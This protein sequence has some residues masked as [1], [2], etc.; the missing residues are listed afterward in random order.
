MTAT[1]DGRGGLARR[2]LGGFFLCLLAGCAR[3]EGRASAERPIEIVVPSAA[4]TLDPRFSTD[5]VAVRTTRLAHAGLFRLDPDT[6]EPIPYA[7]STYRWVDPLTLEVGLR[8]DVRFHDGKRLE[9]HDVCATL[10]ALLDP[11]LGSPHRAV[12]KD[13][14]RCDEVAPTIVRIVLGG[15]H[16]TLLTDLEVPILR[17]DQAASPPRPDGELDGL[18]PFRIAHASDGVVE[19]APADGSP[20]PKPRHAVVVRTVHDENARALRL[21]AGR[22]D[23][24][25]NAISPTLLPALDGTSGLE[26][27]TREGANVTY[28]V[29]DNARAPLSDV[30]V[31][32]ALA[33]GIDRELIARTLLAGRATVAATIFPPGSMAAPR[34]LAA[35]PFAPE[36]ARA[37]FAALGAKRLTL[38]TSTDR[39]RITVARAIAQELSDLGLDVE[40]VPLDLGVLL[41]RLSSGDFD[42]A[43]LQMP[44][45]TEP[46]ILRWFFHSASIPSH[47]RPAGGANRARYRSGEVDAWLDEAAA[48]NDHD[49]R[50]ALYAKVARK[51]SEDLPVVPLWHESQVAVV[52]SRAHGFTLSAEGR[53]LG[54]AGL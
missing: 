34:D 53:W 50:A 24:A 3:A 52:S 44:E 8:T 9:A 26:I 51:L 7:A 4:A 18:G 54:V 30:A 46:N 27:H 25:P 33:Q 22:A 36:A 40:V 17:A 35:V 6:L 49:A 12:V 11:K 28:L 14:A 32:H 29:L 20:L 47:D 39:L 31:R 43:T 45:L 13:I 10:R 19:L 42:M 15:P 1:T 38:L 16:A 48:T 2:R 5:A 37:T 41:Q 23:I 21:S